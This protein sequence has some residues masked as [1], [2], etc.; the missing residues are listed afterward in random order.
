MAT[1]KSTQISPSTNT[2][3][4]IHLPVFT[5]QVKNSKSILRASSDSPATHIS[6]ETYIS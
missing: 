3:R 1:R 5:A 6:T 4:V 2:A